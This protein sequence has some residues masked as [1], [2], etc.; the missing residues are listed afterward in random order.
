MRSLLKT[1]D[2]YTEMDLFPD[3]IKF[4]MF[5]DKCLDDMANYCSRPQNTSR[6]NKCID[7]ANYHQIKHFTGHYKDRYKVGL[8]C[9]YSDDT[10]EEN[11]AEQLIEKYITNYLSCDDSTRLKNVGLLNSDSVVLVEIPNSGWSIGVIEDQNSDI[12]LMRSYVYPEHIFVEVYHKDLE[13]YKSNKDQRFIIPIPICDFSKLMSCMCVFNGKPNGSFR[14]YRKGVLPST[15]VSVKSTTSKPVL[16]DTFS[17]MPEDEYMSIKDLPQFIEIKKNSDRFYDRKNRVTDKRKLIPGHIYSLSYSRERLLIEKFTR[18]ATISSHSYPRYLYLGSI[19]TSTVPDYAW[20]DKKDALLRF[21]KSLFLTPSVD[22]ISRDKSLFIYGGPCESSRKKKFKNSVVHVFF[23]VG[24]LTRADDEDPRFYIKSDA[25]FTKEAFISEVLN[26]VMPNT[27]KRL[28]DAY[29]SAE[30]MSTPLTIPSP[31]VSDMS[32]TS[33]SLFTV[34][35]VSRINMGNLVDMG[36]LFPGSD[37]DFNQFFVEITKNSLKLFEEVGIGIYPDRDSYITKNWN[38]N[39][40][41]IYP[42]L[43]FL[44]WVTPEDYNKNPELKKAIIGRLKFGFRFALNVLIRVLDGLRIISESTAAHTNFS[45]YIPQEAADVFLDY[46]ATFKGTTIDS[47]DGW[48]LIKR[49]N[50]DIVNIFTYEDNLSCYNPISRTMDRPITYSSISEDYFKALRVLIDQNRQGLIQV[51]EK[52]NKLVRECKILAPTNISTLR[53]KHQDLLKE[54]IQTYYQW[55]VDII[56]DESTNGTN[57]YSESEFG[58]WIKKY[59]VT[60]EELVD[61]DLEFE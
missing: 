2:C 9:D 10:T 31:P 51:F 41:Y 27:L 35:D 53:D 34:K 43:Q 6:Y 1:S 39:D 4:V 33:P 58:Y 14:F 56:Y 29:G 3:T 15:K 5:S 20:E 12:D 38:C 23:N 18:E 48:D 61:Y 46:P 49:V 37:F 30:E 19:D 32:N 45:I 52:L 11:L 54:I 16:L 40:T 55:V 17:V 13:K 60:K 7:T 44:S 47:T 21:G 57:I 26:M 8:L 28:L 25:L 42:N 36:E 22:N 24:Q 50:K 59:N